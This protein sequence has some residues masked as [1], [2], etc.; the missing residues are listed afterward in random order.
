LF[1]PNKP[2]SII[3]VAFGP[4]VDAAEVK[5]IADATH[6]ESHV[7]RDPR[8]ITQVLLQAILDAAAASR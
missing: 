7:T 2:V 8:T 3:V 6:G 1:D 4:Q 5:P